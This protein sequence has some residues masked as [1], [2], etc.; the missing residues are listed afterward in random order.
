MDDDWLDAEK[1]RFLADVSTGSKALPN[2]AVLFS[3][4]FL[5]DKP[6]FFVNLDTSQVLS[7]FGVPSTSWPYYSLSAIMLCSDVELDRSTWDRSMVSHDVAVLGRISKFSATVEKVSLVSQPDGKIVV[8][9]DLPPE[10]VRQLTYPIKNRI[11]HMAFTLFPVGA[12]T[13]LDQLAPARDMISLDL[14]F[15]FS[16]MMTLEETGWKA[17]QPRP[18]QVGVLARLTSAVSRRKA[19]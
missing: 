3:R 11:Q 2:A 8:Y 1:D 10:T 7:H 14:E 13:L 4:E 15:S 5:S 12:T 9:V 18:S 16:D 6:G 17:P 19:S